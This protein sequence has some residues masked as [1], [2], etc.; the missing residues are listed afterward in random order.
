MQRF[1][2]LVDM[3]CGVR[4]P[5]D[6]FRRSLPPIVE[7]LSNH[8][9]TGVGVRQSNSMYH[10]RD[11]LSRTRPN[12]SRKAMGDVGTVTYR[13]SIVSDSNSHPHRLELAQVQSEN[14]HG[15]VLLKR[16]QE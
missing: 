13:H 7:I 5:A 1:L 15:R 3:D 16:E 8:A 9:L 10:C 11:C 14:L 2:R 6:I 12:H 4:S